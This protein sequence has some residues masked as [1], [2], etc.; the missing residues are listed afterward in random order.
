MNEHIKSLLKKTEFNEN[1]D[2]V[3]K[4]TVSKPMTGNKISF[5]MFIIL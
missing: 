5:V 4:I 3:I 1:A 2:Q